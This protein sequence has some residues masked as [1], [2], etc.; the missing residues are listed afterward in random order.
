M[1]TTYIT[2][3]DGHELQ[4]T[5][6]RNP[7][8]V[9]HFT[10]VGHVQDGI[11]WRCSEILGRHLRHRLTFTSYYNDKAARAWSMGRLLHHEMMQQ[12]ECAKWEARLA[13]QQLAI[14]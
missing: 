7:S 1:E 10:Q 3:S 14:A 8:A 5:S 2:T 4:L 11:V 13:A 6:E 12:E 9:F